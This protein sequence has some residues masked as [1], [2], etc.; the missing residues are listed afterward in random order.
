M[1]N[2]LIQS[3]ETL[4]NINYIVKSRV[5]LARLYIGNRSAYYKILPQVQAKQYRLHWLRDV[6]SGFNQA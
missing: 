2:Q 6:V 1:L 4:T 5:L 3:S